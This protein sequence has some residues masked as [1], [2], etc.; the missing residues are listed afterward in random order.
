MQD[1]EI[2]LL[3]VCLAKGLQ[4]DNFCRARIEVFS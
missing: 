3:P 1:L 2:D 4:F